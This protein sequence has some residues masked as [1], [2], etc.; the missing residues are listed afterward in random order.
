LVRDVPEAMKPRRIP[1]NG[2]AANDKAKLAK[3]A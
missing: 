1:V 2:V 3:A